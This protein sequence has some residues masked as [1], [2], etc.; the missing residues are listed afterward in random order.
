METKIL[1]S[2]LRSGKSES[3]WLAVPDGAVGLF[4]H[5]D[6][7]AYV[8]DKQ[9]IQVFVN[10]RIAGGEP[11]SLGG[12]GYLGGDLLGKDALVDSLAKR[13]LTVGIPAKTEEIMVELT[14]DGV[15]VCDAG[16]EFIMG[17]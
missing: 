12:G 3:I 2:Q 16:V 6:P 11:F 4:V 10:G 13:G 7:K 9:A 14:V 8:D 17:A 5:I 1:D 15:I